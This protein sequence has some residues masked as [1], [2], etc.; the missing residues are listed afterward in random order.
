MTP[1]ILLDSSGE[2]VL[3]LGSPGGPT[4][5]SSVGQVVAHFV[6]GMSLGD[7]VAAPR[8]HHQWM[9]DMVVAEPLPPSEL[10]YLEGLGHRF[11]TLGR[12]IGDVQAIARTDFGRFTPVSDPR[13]RGT[14][15]APK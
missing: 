14:V 10:A 9:P 3:V 12:P 7:A 4:I 5:I 15:A 13:G 6:S 8:I 11:R 1:T 2:V